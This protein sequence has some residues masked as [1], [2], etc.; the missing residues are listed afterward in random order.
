MRNTI[1]EQAI[2]NYSGSNRFAKGYNG[3]LQ[4][5]Q[6]IDNPEHISDEYHGEL[7]HECLNKANNTIK[8]SWNK[9]F[10]KYYTIQK[11]ILRRHLK[12]CKLSPWSFLFWFRF[13]T[14]CIEF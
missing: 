9:V 8:S 1:I 4:Y 14:Q 3:Y 5:K 7:L 12:T 13:K 6:L 10:G 11:H 2:D